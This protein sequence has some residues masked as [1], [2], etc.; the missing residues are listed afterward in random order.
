[1]KINEIRLDEYATEAHRK[2]VEAIMKKGGYKKIGA[3]LDAMVY[4][5]DSNTVMKVIFPADLDD[6]HAAMRTFVEFYKFCR[7][8]K[9]RHLPRF[10]GHTT[11]DIDGERFY[12]IVQERLNHIPEGSANEAVVWQLSDVATGARNSADW[13]EALSVLNDV[14]SWQHFGGEFDPY[15]LV[16]NATPEQLANWKGLYET[17]VQAHLKMPGFTGWDLHTENVM[18]RADGTLVIVDPWSSIMQ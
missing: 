11:L 14:D 2:K 18:E 16:D 7:R 17:M 15:G 8:T 10:S 13:N 1:M 3:G 12:A 5:K 6:M 4:A 9:S